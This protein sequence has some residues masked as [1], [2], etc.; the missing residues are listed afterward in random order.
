MKDDEI[1]V[2][3]AAVAKQEFLELGYVDASMRNISGKAGLT[4]GSLYNR[5]KDK[6]EL[7]EYIVGDAV[8]NV[9]DKFQSFNAAYSVDDIAST[10][11]EEEQYQESAMKFIIDTMFDNYDSFDLVINKGIGSPYENFMEK[12]IAVAT[13]NTKNYVFA[14]KKSIKDP[15]VA[16]DI[17]HLLNV[18]LFDAIAEIF[19]KHY[20]KEQ[21]D[22]YMMNIFHF[23]NAGWKAI[24]DTAE[25]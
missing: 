11:N 17:T 1:K 3:I 15:S 13:E 20:T 22:F 24:L 2:K 8:K 25:L 14:H 6:A 23:Y 5:F 12:L 10:P 4:T 19:R 21:A 18:A 7:F 9:F 16:E